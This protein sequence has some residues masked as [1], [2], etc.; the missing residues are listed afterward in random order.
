MGVALTRGYGKGV[1]VADGLPVADAS[2]GAR[3]W[4]ARTRSVGGTGSGGRCW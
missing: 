4:A 3:P 1:P 2:G